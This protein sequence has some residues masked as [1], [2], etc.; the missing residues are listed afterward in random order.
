ML[1]IFVKAI[2]KYFQVC[3]FRIPIIEK[4]LHDDDISWKRKSNVPNVIIEI[5]I[6]SIQPFSGIRWNK[7]FNW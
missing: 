7:I 3:K 5:L 6:L 4:I 2:L 1:H